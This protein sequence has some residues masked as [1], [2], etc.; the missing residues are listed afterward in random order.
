MVRVEIMTTSFCSGRCI[1]CPYPD[2]WYAKNPGIMTTDMFKEIISRHP[3][4][5]VL[6]MYLFND[7]FL[8]SR[9][10]DLME[11]AKSISDIKLFNISTN[12]SKIPRDIE[13]IKDFNVELWVSFHGAD[14]TTYEAIMGLDYDNTMNNI[15]MLNDM[16][17]KFRIRGAG[18]SRTGNIVLFTEQQFFEHFNGKGIV[19]ELEYFTFHDRAGNSKNVAFNVNVPDQDC[20]RYHDWFHYDNTGKELLCCHAYNREE[21][22]NKKL[23]THC[24]SRGG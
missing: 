1:F 8:D 6:S 22:G 4:I 16:G 7:P 15:K 18:T 10:F 21:S 2:S 11:L 9:I 12:A 20:P 14:K 5:D 23:C 24:I 19:Q 3:K 17:L 13:R